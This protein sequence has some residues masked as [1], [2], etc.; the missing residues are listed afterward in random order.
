MFGDNS[1]STP[2]SLSRIEIHPL[3]RNVYMWMAMGLLVTTAVA[4]Y[5]SSSASLIELLATNQLLFF[6]AIIG[7]LAL[8]V[9]LSAAINRMS[10]TVAGIMFF[11]YSA[12]NGF[13]L[14]LIFVVYS[15]GSIGVAF[16]VTAILFGVMT[17]IGMTT[18]VDLS[19]YST[20]F[21]MGL[22][23]LVI[24]MVVNMFLGSS[25]FDYLISVV[26]VV[27]FTA[28]TAYDTQQIQAMANA[29]G[30]ENE[31]QETLMKLSIM[32]ALRLYLDFINLFLFLLRLLGGRD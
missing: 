32:G 28:L 30:I 25:A 12:L 13:T 24:A 11:V 19:K 9:A 10:A 17:V 27:L 21:M 7:Q 6:G 15:I 14:S 31:G 5:V 23:G 1:Q 18:S 26:G 8:V 20:Y 29:P 3:M 16:G 2:G 22:I 4:L